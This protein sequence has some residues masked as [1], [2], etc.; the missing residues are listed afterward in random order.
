[1]PL[2]A[3]MA[4]LALAESRLRLRRLSTV[5]V[6]LA[7]IILSWSMIPDPQGSSQLSIL[8][9]ARAQVAYTSAALAMG[10]AKLAAIVFGL[11]G[12][13]LV[14]GRAAED[15]RSGIGS[16][17]GASHASNGLLLA[18]RWLGGLMY[19]GALALALMLTVLLCHLMRGSGPVQLLV[20]LQTY[21][22]MLLPLLCF[23][24]S[25]AILCD[26]HAR[27]M[28][29]TGDILFFLLW[30]AQFPIADNFLRTNPSEMSAWMLV[31]FSG[32]SVSAM[33]VAG[34]LSMPVKAI[35]K[36]FTRFDPALVQVVL[37]AT[38]WTLEMIA[39]RAA[40]L[41]AAM[42][43]LLPALLL[44]H[45]YSP[46]KVKASNA[47]RRRTPLA[48]LNSAL[49][50]L[51][52]LA[53]PL[54]RLSA[55]LPGLAGQVCADVALCLV[56]APAAIALA[57]VANMAALVASGP[58]LALV[59]TAACACWGILASEL[60]VRDYNASIEDLSGAVPGGSGR[61][62][63][64]HILSAALLGLLFMG[65]VALR[66]SVEEPL[67]AL[68]LLAGIASFSA[69][70]TLC[71]STARTSRLFMA[72]FLFWLY[73]ANGVA[74]VPLLDAFG[75]SGAAN[76]G[77]VLAQCMVAVVACMAAVVYNRHQLR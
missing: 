44:F 27:L 15:L 61:R 76:T 34:A 66:W 20:Y 16:V 71:G 64:R 33:S 52:R 7:V 58:V 11:A 74:D 36:G 51:S 39:L 29:K 65:M 55:R 13:Y 10:S 40:T 18:S 48:L 59:L 60:S 23:T 57:I 42:L 43:P 41:L 3:L 1:M 50:P 75:A 56:A 28:G 72:L 77:S 6:L 38:V 49:R 30:I 17:I 35:S 53:Q 12:F 2:F 9:V 69:L 70:A 21:V 46:D 45:R 8:T 26:S 37:P 24:V 19:L 67:R 31:D 5:L 22:A 68:A 25:C 32:L 47:R 73:V 14:R 54:L 4:S 62:T 63:L